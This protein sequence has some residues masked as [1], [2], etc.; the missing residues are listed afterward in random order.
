MH[1]REEGS[2]RDVERLT[3]LPTNKLVC[4]KLYARG[5]WCIA[6]SSRLMTFSGGGKYDIIIIIY[7]MKHIASNNLCEGPQEVVS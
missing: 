6:I 1:S 2:K 3:R 4:A 5:G 7:R